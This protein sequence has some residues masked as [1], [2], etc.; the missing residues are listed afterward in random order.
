M[1]FARRILDN[2]GVLGHFS[3]VYGST[4]GLD[5]DRKPEL[6][7]HIL[8]ERGLTP[9]HC[10]MVGDRKFDILGAHANKVRAVGVLWGYGS[11]NELESA[12]ADTLLR[13]P[14][15]LVEMFGAS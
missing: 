2:E 3:G 8:R 15:E 11:L 6:I 14:S 7:A 4:P 9:H 5:I 1:E 12:G 10:M 13:R